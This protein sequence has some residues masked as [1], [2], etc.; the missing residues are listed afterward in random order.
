VDGATDG[1]ATRLRET[2]SYQSVKG[3]KLTRR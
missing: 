1:L 2:Q 3:K